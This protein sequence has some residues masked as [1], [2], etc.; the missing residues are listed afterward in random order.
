MGKHDK[1]LAKILSGTS[2]GNIRFSEL[3]SLLEKLG[4]YHR[5][6]GSHYIYYSENVADIINLQ[7]L[8]SKAKDYQVKQVRNVILKYKLGGSFYA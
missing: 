3:C 2:D 5:I 6:S 1:L 4:F 8:G 7:P